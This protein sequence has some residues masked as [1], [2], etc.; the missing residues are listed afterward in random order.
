MYQVTEPNLLRKEM[1]KSEPHVKCEAT[2]PDE[3]QEDVTEAA[4]IN[5]IS[6]YELNVFIIQAT[7][8]KVM[9]SEA[10]QPRKKLEQLGTVMKVMGGGRGRLPSLRRQI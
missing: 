6:L 9:G 1:P 8:M 4:G 2:Y 3:K 10:R 7:V 5:I